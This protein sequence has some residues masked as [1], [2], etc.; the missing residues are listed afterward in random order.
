MKA[1]TTNKYQIIRAAEREAMSDT[2]RMIADTYTIYERDVSAVLAR[3]DR[4]SPAPL[5]R[6]LQ[7][8]RRRDETARA[9]PAT[10]ESIDEVEAIHAEALEAIA[11]NDR[12]SRRIT[13]AE[14]DRIAAINEGR[15]NRATAQRARHEAADLAEVVSRTLSE[16]ADLVQV[17]AAADTRWNTIIAADYFTKSA[18][19][20]ARTISAIMW[21]EGKATADS[22]PADI[23]AAAAMSYR[24][25]AVSR[26]VR[27]QRSGNALN[28]MHT[29][30]R[31]ASP[32]EVA[33]WIASGKATGA[34]N[35]QPTRSGYITLEHRTQTKSRPA[36]WYFV[37]RRYTVNQW[38]SI[39]QL[40]ENGDIIGYIRTVNVY[41][42]NLEAVERLEALAG[43]AELTAREREWLAVFSSPAAIRAAAESRREYH[44]EAGAKATAA[45]A[46]AAEWTG[47]KAYTFERIGITNAENR[48]QFY[49]RM[50]RRLAKAAPQEHTVQTPEEYAAKDWAYWEAMQRDSRRGTAKEQTRRPD[51]VGNMHK[52]AEQIQTPQVVQFVQ[53]APIFEAIA[54]TVTGWRAREPRSARAAAAVFVA[55]LDT[56]IDN[57]TPEAR[58]RAEA[59]ARA[60]AEKHRAADEAKSRAKARAAAL[61]DMERRAAEN[62][63]AWEKEWSARAAHTMT[64]AEWNAIPAAARLATLDRIHAEGKRLE[65]VRG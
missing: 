32:E 9:N 33:A 25:N 6:Q 40:N 41:A 57:T 49:S 60:Y 7:N 26:Y 30:T 43:A 8:S 12:V 46:S 22:T 63:Q 13:A 4:T 50:T 62:R 19:D 21:A 14:A 24:R 64:A 28:G 52:A 48:R 36:G 17:A 37:S 23:E 10:A 11:D 56:K 29:D 51:L 18:E 45:G 3:L 27:G 39:E 20:S 15:A 47:R 16:R 35:K 61:A 2:A 65:I 38:H 42:E 55:L 5:I 53:T 31:P 58:A 54:P 1:T 34:E 44:T 59:A